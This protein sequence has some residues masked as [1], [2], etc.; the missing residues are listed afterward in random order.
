MR[1][2]VGDMYRCIGKESRSDGTR[3]PRFAYI[4]RVPSVIDIAGFTRITE[5]SIRHSMELSGLQVEDWMAKKEYDERKRPLLHLYVEMKRE[6]L[7][8]SAISEQVLRDHLSVYFKYVDNDYQDLK[9]ILGMD[10]LKITI[11][12]CGTFRTYAEIYGKSIQKMNPKER[13]VSD[14]LAC[15]EKATYKIRGESYYG[16]L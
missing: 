16:R 2:R 4:D 8:N 7:T 1:Y 10:P 5:N 3:I 9:K 6:A 12:K 15:R 11:L 13:D 14:L